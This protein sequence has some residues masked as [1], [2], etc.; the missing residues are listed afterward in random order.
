MVSDNFKYVQLV[1][2]MGDKSNLKQI[3]QQTLIDILGD[4]EIVN[5]ILERQKSSM[6]NDLNEVDEKSLV[7]FAAYIIKHYNYKNEL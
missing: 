5:K 2:L 6:G 3:D 7:D 4:E 1:H